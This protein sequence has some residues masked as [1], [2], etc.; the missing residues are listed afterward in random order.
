M[1]FEQG[2][3][4]LNVAAKNLD[5]IGNNVANAST[6]GYK[7]ERAEFADVFAS[8]LAGGGGVQVGIGAKVAAVRQ[9][10]TQGNIT[11]TSNPLDVAING[12]GFFRLSTN[13][14]VS[15]SRN[16]QFSLDQNGFMVT[17]NGAHLTGY[18]AD[19]NGQ[20]VASTPVDLQVSLANIAPKTTSTAS[21]AINLDSRATV[22]TSAFNMTNPASYTSST[23]MTVY[24]S[25]GNSHTLTT[26]YVKTAS[27]TWD[28]YG[29]AD[30]TILNGGAAIGTLNFGAGGTLAA[31]VTM[32][33]SIPLTNGAASPLAIPVTY[34]ASDM[35]QFGVAFAVNKLQQD[36]YTTGT[37][38]GFSIGNDGTILGR[39]TNGQTRAQGQMVLANFVNPQGLVALGNNQ[40]AESADSGQALVSAPGSG[41]LGV[42]QSGAL[43]DANVDL[44][45][46]L[47]NMITAQRAYQANAQ[48][49]KTQDQINQTLVNLR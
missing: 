32:N 33:V 37:L 21:L 28:V 34:P 27:N 19:A 5:A 49:I 13:G 35:S 10:F 12:S 11:T 31:D 16:G 38:A 26:Y 48:T 17:A 25:Q 8:S 14:T 3:S 47:V 29:A 30:G 7:A 22:P 39:Y 45:A 18:P 42:L 2:L 41:T 44:T 40:W 24:D 15:Y 43:E 4:G 9:Q 23:A 46:E 1:S 36:G 20:I 6:I